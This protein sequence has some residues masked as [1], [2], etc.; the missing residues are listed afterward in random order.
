MTKPL[1]LLLSVLAFAA[2]DNMP[3]R[4]ASDNKSMPSTSRSDATVAPTAGDTASTNGAAAGKAGN[5]S[6][7]GNAGTKNEPGMTEAMPSGMAPK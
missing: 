6:D 4:S 1:I 3:N 5:R 7:I 2:C